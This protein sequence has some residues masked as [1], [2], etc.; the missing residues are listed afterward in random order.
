[1]LK[2]KSSPQTHILYKIK[3]NISI[4]LHLKFKTIAHLEENKGENLYELGF[5]DS[6]L[7]STPKA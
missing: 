1:M 6:F 7:D 3:L 4:D 5:G 2:K